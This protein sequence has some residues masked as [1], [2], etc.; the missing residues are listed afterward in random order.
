MAI[1]LGSVGSITGAGA[2]NYLDRPWSVYVATVSGT[3]YAFVVSEFDDALSIFD[4]S[5]PETPSFT[6]G[7]RGAGAPNFLNQPRDVFVYTVGGTEYAFVVSIGDNSLSIFDVSTPA[8]PSFT[9]V[10]SGAGAPNYIEVP[11]GVFVTTIGGTEYALVTSPSDD[12]A[13]TIIDVSTPG[14]PALSGV[15]MG[16]GAPNYLG[17]A[18]SVHVATIGGTEYAFVASVDDDAL[19]IIDVSTPATPAFTGFI[20]GTGTLDGASS[21]YVATVGGT[22]YAFVASN[23]DNALSIIDV[24]TPATPSLTGSLAGD[25]SPNFLNGARSV[26]VATVGGVEY[27]FVASPTDNALSIIDVSTP[28]T[29]TLAGAVSGT[30]APDYLDGA[31]YV[32]VYTNYIFVASESDDALSVMAFTLDITSTVGTDGGLRDYTLLSAWEADK[33]RNLV[34]ANETE[35]AECYNDGVMSNTCTI[36]GWTT[37]A[38][39]GITIYTPTAE[40]HTGTLGTGFQYDGGSSLPI[41]ITVPNVT[42]EGLSIKTTSGGNMCIQTSMDAAARGSISISH[43]L[44]EGSGIWLLTNSATTGFNFYVW[45]NMCIGW[46]SFRTGPTGIYVYVNTSNV[47]SYLYNNSVF[48]YLTGGIRFQYNQANA[49][50]KNCLAVA[51]V[52]DF[53]NPTYVHG[54]SEYNGSTALVGDADRAPGSNSIFGLVAADTFVSVTGGSEDLHTKDSSSD[55]FQAGV[56]L[57]GDAA[58]PFSDDIDGETRGLP[59]DMGAD[60]NLAAVVAAPVNSLVQIAM[61]MMGG[62][63]K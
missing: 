7:I 21:V 15:I 57:S 35:T 22:E 38:N 46:N 23:A 39:R 31:A 52:V 24:S 53:Q 43:N 16:S 1:S 58:L 17:G 3:E 20:S 6:G 42:V 29:P 12:D 51:C 14:T 41:N 63:K 37:D 4:V 60:N 49:I 33:Q 30:G 34:T 45:N 48:G 40:R 54:D 32:F 56:D 9:G 26:H 18:R 27:A 8:T 2:P 10:I 47:L 61:M 44:C 28:G 59:W 36:A 62:G 25:G 11:T 19:S 5:T 50:V 55:Q 13:L